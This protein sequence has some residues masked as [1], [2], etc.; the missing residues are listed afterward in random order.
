MGH[1][2]DGIDSYTPVPY[3]NRDAFNFVMTKIDILG[4]KLRD[5]SVTLKAVET[6][7]IVAAK[8]D[9]STL[10]KLDNDINDLYES[11]LD[12]QHHLKNLHTIFSG[13]QTARVGEK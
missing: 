12:L 9:P 8:A 1:R 11:A 3:S 5:V 13:R 7:G 6:R 2:Q 4:R 10:M